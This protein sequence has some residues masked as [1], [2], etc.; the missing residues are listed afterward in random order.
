[1]LRRSHGDVSGF[2]TIA[3]CRDGLKNSHGKSATSPFASGKRGKSATRPRQ[4][5]GKSAT[6]RTNQRGRHVFVAD[7]T[8][9]SAIGIVELGL[10]CARPPTFPLRY[11]APRPHGR[12]GVPLY[13]NSA[14]DI[15][16]HAQANWPLIITRWRIG[17]QGKAVCAYYNSWCDVV[18]VSSFY[19][20]YRRHVATL[21]Y[22]SDKTHLCRR[23]YTES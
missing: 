14:V 17:S 19:D 21:H 18:T 11:K 3:T 9:K 2:Q 4:D 13:S 5:T 15:V 10:N 8:G 12:G 6:S 16:P 23:I 7:F 1:M 22:L 20:T